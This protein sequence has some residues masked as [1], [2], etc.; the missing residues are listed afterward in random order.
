MHFYINERLKA[1]PNGLSPMKYRT[2]A[3]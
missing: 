2:K 3:A 1:K